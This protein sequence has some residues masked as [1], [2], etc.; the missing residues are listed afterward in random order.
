MLVPRTRSEVVLPLGATLSVVPLAIAGYIFAVFEPVAGFQFQDRFVWYEP[1]GIAWHLGL[2]GISMP[3][4]V[5]TAILVP[6]SLV[7]STS[8]TERQKEFVVFT[9]LLEAGML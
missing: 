8:I 5:L 4:V 7:A 3:L 9:L 6:L 1:W 2:D